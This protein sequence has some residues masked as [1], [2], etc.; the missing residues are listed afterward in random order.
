VESD[1]DLAYLLPPQLYHHVVDALRGALPAPATDTPE[2]LRRRDY[3]A[4]S[5]IA[6]MLPANGEEAMLAAQ[7][8]AA[9]AQ[10]L[11]CL[12]LVRQH[13]AD[14]PL[15]LKC[16]AQAASMMRQAR[17][18]RSLLL[19]CQARRQVREANDT[20][21]DA[22]YRLEHAVLHLMADAL[23]TSAVKPAEPAEHPAEPDQPIEHAPGQPF[24]PSSPESGPGAPRE[25]PARSDRAVADQ[26]P[27]TGLA[28][29]PSTPIVHL[30]PRA[31]LSR[32][33]Y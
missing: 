11:D 26:D 7:F 33:D 17:S 25:N 19:T 4:I 20:T 16:L 13:A 3:A 24:E 28:A 12:R 18:A 21:C 15:G 9:S 30:T 8:V 27:P 14:S 31:N 23:P 29:P 6:A 22:G 10:A 2:D 32:M 1:L 5:Q